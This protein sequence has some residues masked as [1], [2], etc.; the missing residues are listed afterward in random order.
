MGAL[1]QDA[2]AKHTSKAQEENSQG[3]RIKQLNKEQNEFTFKMQTTG[4]N[5]NNNYIWNL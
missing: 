3:E 5:L 2:S 1:S 4:Q